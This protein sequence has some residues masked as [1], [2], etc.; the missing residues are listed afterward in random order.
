MSTVTTRN[1]T[2]PLGASASAAADSLPTWLLVVVLL[3]FSLYSTYA[4]IEV[5]Y[6][7]IITSHF[8]VAGMQVF[9]DLVIAL[10]LACAWMVHDARQIGRAAWPFVLLTFALGSIGPLLY[11]VT[12][13]AG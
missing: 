8:H 5:G 7:G 3:P 2:R 13:R 6:L 4:V 9:A 10:L 1:S 11:L 12:R